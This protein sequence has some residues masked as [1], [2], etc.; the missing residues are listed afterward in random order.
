MNRVYA[1]VRLVIGV[2]ALYTVVR[3][4]MEYDTWAWTFTTQSNALAGVVMLWGGAALLAGRQG[5]PLWL[6]G[7]ATLYLSITALVYNLVLGYP[8]DLGP[9]VLFGLENTFYQ[10]AITP[11]LVLLVWILALPHRVLKWRYALYWLSYLLVYL[12]LAIFRNEVLGAE[13]PYPFIDEDTIGW[14]GLW[15]NVAIYAALFY[16]LGL[17][18]VGLDRLL[19]AQTRLTETR[20]HPARDVT[21]S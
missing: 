20:A 4:A 18:L 7:A 14:S 16:A 1:V 15:T 8:E 6:H 11:T 3:S 17:A 5:P 21:Q 9:Q 13:Y 19:P 10:H 12:G 2:L